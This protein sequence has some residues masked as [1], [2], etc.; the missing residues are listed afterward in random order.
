[1]VYENRNIVLSFTNASYIV[2]YPDHH[3]L[4]R[5]GGLALLRFVEFLQLES[6][7]VSNGITIA[8]VIAFGKTE[9]Q[10]L[11]KPPQYAAR[12]LVRK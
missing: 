10:E 8:H 5:K 2:S 3:A 11:C 4:R 6:D 1:M 12:F 9:L 7:H